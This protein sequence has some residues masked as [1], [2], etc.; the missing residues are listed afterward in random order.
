LLSEY[1]AARVIVGGQTMNPS[2]EDFLSAIASLTSSEIILLPNNGNVIMAAQQAANM[3]EGRTIR[4]V[5]SKTIQQGITALLAYVDLQASG[6][7][8]TVFNGMCDNLNQVISGE[9]TTAIRDTSYD[10]LAVK[11][12]ANIG[13]INGKLKVARETVDETVTAL[14][15]EAHAAKYELVTLYYGADVSEKQAQALARKLAA[16]FD[17][18]EFEVIYGG[19]P[20][21]PYLISIE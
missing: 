9:I 20:L 7:L 11:A 19:Q 2:T 15:H 14:L 17:K 5:P 10:G 8:E 1:G 13:L 18:L 4:V 6:S 21:Y 16:V 12:G 3:V